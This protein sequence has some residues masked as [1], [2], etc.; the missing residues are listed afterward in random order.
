MCINRKNQLQKI[1]DIRGL[2]VVVGF[3]FSL[4]LKAQTDTVGFDSTTIIEEGVKDVESEDQT[5]IGDH[6]YFRNKDDYFDSLIVQQRNVPDGRVKE[7][8][9]DKAFWYANNNIK[10][11]TEEKEDADTPGY[12]PIGQSTWFQTLL[13]L[14]IIGGFA[15]A[16]MWYL[17]SSNVGLFRKRNVVNTGQDEIDEM[18]ENIFEINY[19]RE[20][21][22]AASQGNYR[23]AV[24]LMY[25]RLLKNLAGKNIIQYKQDR[26][27]FD[28]LMQLQPSN[29]YTGFFRLTRNYEYSWY[30][31]FQVS[32]EA[33]TI[34]RK[35]FDQFEN[36]L[37]RT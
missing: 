3:F 15:A 26:T 23:L 20:I 35:D 10:K 17:S 25:L 9:K 29:Y 12:T 30:G 33:Y 28:Y 2:F 21:E 27:N 7:M 6:Q 19:Q 36:Q 5:T 32:E 8:Q 31:Q 22:K 11:K 34:I 13:W 24:R 37:P 18:P 4:S 14:V 1:F 16:L